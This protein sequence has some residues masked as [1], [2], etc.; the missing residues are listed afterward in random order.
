MATLT[1]P[2]PAAVT[3]GLGLTLVCTERGLRQVRFTPGAEPP[4]AAERR[5]AAAFA[6]EHPWFWPMV[7]AV[8]Q[9]W[10]KQPVDFSTVPLDLSAV[11]PFRR[12]V[13]QVCAR[14]GYGQRATYTELAKRAGRPKAVRAAGSAMATNPVPIVVP[15]HRVIRTDR[16]LGGYGG[17]GGLEL[18]SRLLALEQQVLEQRK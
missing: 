6:T 1:W 14:I 5:Q 9:F 10:K 16:T 12:A 15:C 4:T 13:L 3:G 11:P 18:K 2:M 8:E 17:P 7:R